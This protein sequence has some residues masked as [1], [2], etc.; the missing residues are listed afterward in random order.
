MYANCLK[1]N[2][3]SNNVISGF[4]QWYYSLLCSFNNNCWQTYIC[5][6][7][8]GEN[9]DS[10]TGISQTN[11]R[12][13]FSISTQEQNGN[14]S[15]TN[16]LIHTSHLQTSSHYVACCRINLL[17]FYWFAHNSDVDCGSSSQFPEMDSIAREQKRT[18]S[19]IIFFLIQNAGLLSGFTIILMI[20]M[21]AGQINLG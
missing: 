4:I 10:L 21:F 5:Y 12:T 14:S 13:S 20:T 15:C 2:L 9:P 6:W 17:Y 18:S 8:K 1:K 16:R 19:K 11:V 7:Q 3:H